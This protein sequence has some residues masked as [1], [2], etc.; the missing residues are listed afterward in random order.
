MNASRTVLIRGSVLAGCLSAGAATSVCVGQDENWDLRN[1]H[2]YNGYAALHG[3]FHTDLAAASLQSWI[4]PALD[5]PYAWLA[6]GPL[7]AHPKI[8]TAFMGL[9]YGALLA[10]VLG[11]S[12][13]VYRFLPGRLRWIATL[14]ATAMAATGAAVF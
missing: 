1:Y 3:R 6:L 2:L 11:L 7:A 9:W 5:I 12:W 8:L 10:V 14:A 4:N 13:S